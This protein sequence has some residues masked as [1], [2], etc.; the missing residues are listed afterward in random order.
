MPA[1]RLRLGGVPA[2]TSAWFA[3]QD[4]SP[5]LASRVVRDHLSPYSPHAWP[6]ARSS[7][8]PPLILSVLLPHAATSQVTKLTLLYGIAAL[9]KAYGAAP[10]SLGDLADVVGARRRLR[11]L[12]SSPL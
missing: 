3:A 4:A 7:R 9:R 2:S 5:L 1:E 10:L 11:Q 12:R 8:G 6:E